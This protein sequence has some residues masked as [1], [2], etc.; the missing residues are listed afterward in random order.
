MGGIGIRVR[1]VRSIQGPGV[2]RVDDLVLAAEDDFTV[3]LLLFELV[4]VCSDNVKFVCT[5][6]SEMG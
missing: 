6:R 5:T 2:V 1:Q 3:E 4:C